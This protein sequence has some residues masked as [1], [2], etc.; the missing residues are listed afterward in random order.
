MTAGINEV[1]GD[2]S[3]AV[4]ENI[5]CRWKAIPN[6]LVQNP[7]MKW[8]SIVFQANG[9]VEISYE[10]NSDGIDQQFVGSYEVVH[11]A[12][13][14]RGNPPNIVIRSRHAEIENLNVL[15][16]VRIGEFSYFPPGNPVLWFQDPDGYDYVF[17]PAEIS[18][19]RRM[20]LLYRA[21]TKEEDD[22]HRNTKNNHFQ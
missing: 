15:V 10:M 7:D 4:A 6:S 22:S 8:Q 17:E 16:K 1:P 2:Y 20:K 14:G 18:D 11:K 13:L 21:S 12:K 3:Q 9:N 19:E 5:I